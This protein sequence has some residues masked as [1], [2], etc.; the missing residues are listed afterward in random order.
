M[1][2]PITQRQVELAWVEAEQARLERDRLGVDIGNEPLP[3]QQAVY[4]AALARYHALVRA[5]QEQEQ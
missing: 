4:T 5:Q 1:N 2:A 3:Q